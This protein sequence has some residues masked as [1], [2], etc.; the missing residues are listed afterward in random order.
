MRMPPGE[1][2]SYEFDPTSC[3][4]ELARAILG[5]MTQGG[6]KTKVQVKE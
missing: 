1:A 5:S 6:G 2:P 3:D 4:V